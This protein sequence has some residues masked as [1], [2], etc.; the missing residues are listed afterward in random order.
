MS[1]LSTPPNEHLEQKE[2]EEEKLTQMTKS[3]I[4]AKTSHSE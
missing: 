1:A 4:K 2:K 3:Q